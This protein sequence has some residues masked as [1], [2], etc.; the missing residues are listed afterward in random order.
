ML[1]LAGVLIA[2]AVGCICGNLL[3]ARRSVRT[4]AGD[5]ELDPR[6]N[7][8]LA[9]L[10]GFSHT[11]IPVW[12]AHVKSSRNQMETAIEQLV[13]KFAGIVTLLDSA[14][15]SSRVALAD[16]NADVFDASRHQLAAVVD[17]LDGALGTKRRTLDEL[18]VLMSLNAEMKSMT[19]EVTRIAGQTHLL[20]LNAAI[21]AQRVG[22]EGRA[23]SVVAKEVRELANLSRA[24]GERIGGKANDVSAAISA[25]VAMAEHNAEDEETLVAD[26]NSKVQAVLDD[27]RQLMDGIQDSSIDLGRAAEG[28]KEEIAGSLVQFQFQDRIGQT[29][30]HLQGSI[31]DFPRR[32]D[33]SQ[34]FSPGR[35][36]P[37]DAEGLLESLQDTYTMVE[38]HQVHD[39]GAPVAVQETE[40]TFF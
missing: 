31:D 28:I 11:V 10:N 23:F 38:E 24:T 29:L 17:A 16:E 13:S 20:A 25:A 34:Q 30:E 33:E 12:S 39:A 7:T 2:W 22:E 8:Y 19:G 3:G 5:G 14:L 6:M 37:L 35:L 26:A 1:T 40:I 36:E 15:A 21:E 32:L 18:Q 27:L 4:R 9:S